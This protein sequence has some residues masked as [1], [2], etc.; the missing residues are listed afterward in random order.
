MS[1]F[2]FDWGHGIALAL[3][4]FILFILALIFFADETG[5]LVSDRYYEESLV[6]QSQNIDAKTN[7]NALA[8]KPE[9]IPQANGIKLSFPQE[10]KP[11]SGRILL[12]VGAYEAND[13]RVPI[14]L[15]NMNVQLLPAARLAD[16]ADYDISLRWYQGGKP[17]LIE[18]NVRW[19]LP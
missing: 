16:S 4:S 1:K 10:I 14:Q 19:N 13:I 6:F 11:D 5:D 9:I 12:Q 2:K 8:R 15:D 18:E 3:G 7:V 17:Y